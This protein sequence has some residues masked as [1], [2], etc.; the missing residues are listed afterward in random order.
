MPAQRGSRWLLPWLSLGFATV[1]ALVVTL[2][3]VLSPSQ[4]AQ[5]ASSMPAAAAGFQDKDKLL[6]TVNLPAVADGRTEGSLTLELLT[7]DGRVLDKTTQTVALSATSSSQRVELS[8]HETS[9]DKVTVRCTLDKESVKAPLSQIL[10]VKAHETALSSN[11]EFYAGSTA[12]LRC[13]VHGVKSLAETIPLPHA[14]VEIHLKDKNGKRT[15]LYTGATPANGIASARMQ[16]PAELPAGNYK[17]EVV[18]K[19]TLGEEKLERDVKVKTAPKIL[20]ISDKPLYQPGQ[21]M[22]LRALSLQSYD[23]TPV[24]NMPLTFEVEDAKGNKV[25]KRTLST[26]DHGIASVDF[27]LA[28]EVNT[29]E[30][31]IRAQ[32]GDVQSAKTVTVKPYVLPKF[33]SEL[34]ADKRFYLPRETLNGDLQVD[35]FFGKPVAGAQVV[36][37]AS[38]FDVAFKDFQ[39][40]QGKTDANGHAKFEIK[41][42]DY[43]T[44]LPLEKGNALV[45]LEAKVIDTA[46]HSEVINKTYPVSNQSVQINLIPEGG[47]LVPNMENRIFAAAIYPDG[48]PA[49]ADVSLWQGQKPEGKTLAALKTNE[50]GLAEFKFTPKAEMFRQGEFA[51]RKIEMLGGNTVQAWAPKQL[52]DLTATARDAKGNQAKTLISLTS[53]PLGENVMLRLDK[54]I[55]KGGEALKV[56]I[57]TSAGLPTVYF[58]VVRGG[59]TL[60]TQWLDVKDGVAEQTVELPASVFGTLDV[61]AYQMLGHGEIIRDSRVVYV[62]PASDLK[63]EIKADKDVYL[64][65]EKGNLNF[66]VK[67]AQGKPTAAALGVIIVD[68]AVYAL[69]EMQPG[70]EKVYFTLQ[71]ELLKPQAHI[72]YKP[73]QRIDDLVREPVLADARQQAAEVLFTSI[74]PRMPARWEVNPEFERRQKFDQMMPQIGSALFEV[75]TQQNSIVVLDRQTKTW[76]FAP[77]LLTTTFKQYGWADNTFPDPFGGKLK[78]ASL[79]R[80][81]A[82]CSPERLAHAVTEHRLHYLRAALLNLGNK[83]AAQWRKDDKWTLPGDVLRRGLKESAYPEAWLKDGW[84]NDFRLIRRD[85]KVENPVFDSFE[86][87]SA[88]PDGKLDT[89]DDVRISAANIGQL[90]QIWWMNGRQREELAQ[91]LNNPWMMRRGFGP[92][93]P[94]G[95][96]GHFA[97]GGPPGFPQKP[98]LPPMPRAPQTNQPPAPLGKPGEGKPGVD[99]EQGQGAEAAGAAPVV[100][101]REYFPETMLWQP[102]LITDDRGQASLPLNFADSITT[103]RLTASASSRG[104]LLGG[105]T[106]SL[107]VFQDF[108]ADIDLPV[109]LTRNDEVA[110]PVAVYNYLKTPQTVKLE[111][112][113][114]NWFELTDGLGLTRSLDL[115]PGQVTAVKFR[116]RAKQIG[117]LPLTVKAIGSKMSDSL[118]RSIEVVPDGKR[119]EQVFADRLNGRVN[120][121]ITIPDSALPDASKLLVKVYPGVFS[122]LVEGTEGMLRMPGGCFEQTSSSAY[123]NVLV[124]DYI[125][126]A[127]VASPEVLMK[128]EQY[129]NVGYQRLLTFERPGGGFDWWGSGEP[130]VWLS[131][132]GLSEFNDM[133]RVYPID[134]GVIERT[135]KWLMKQRAEDGTWDKI[136]ATHGESITRMGDPKLLLTSYVVWSLLD[137]GLKTPELNKSI[138]Y[139]RKGVKDA[140]NPYILALAANALASWDSK[141]DSTFEAVQKT[142]RKLESKKQVHE[143]WKA[144]SFPA[145]GHSLSYARGDSLTVETT[146]LAVLA[147]QKSGQ[148][149]TEVNKALMYLVKSKDAHGTWGSTQATIL[150]LK[151]LISG[152]GGS[153]HKG[154]VEFAILVNGKEAGKGEVTEENADVMQLFDLKEHTQRA[155][156]HNVTIEVK[157]ETNLM[158]QVVARHFEGWGEQKIDKPLF[159]VSVDYDRTRLQTS[160]LLKATARLKYNGKEPTSMVMLELG[161]PPG[162]TVD[163]GDFAELVAAKKVN[164]F[165]VTARQVILYLGDV[166][167]GDVQT[168]EYSLKPKYPIKAKT[169]A[170]VVYEYYT[171]ANRAEAKPVELV[172]E[173]K[174]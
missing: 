111:L 89:A 35:Y 90:G 161:V 72:L 152:M 26:S 157:G 96:G 49:Q 100:R 51:E 36:I 24:G 118:K 46:D 62:N 42:P 127:K 98:G 58:D 170:T 77:D 131:A 122:Q 153:P 78:I 85:G 16:L 135:Q 84:G 71:E 130:L 5:A 151:A 126:K 120:Q 167:P 172:V 28:S 37:K 45:R 132:Y 109:S 80:L 121:T 38:T 134:R 156:V 52:L 14:S 65:G 124:V 142:L 107:R 93:G 69:Q 6:I 174:K 75:A 47:R 33:K 115:Q 154:K 95:F 94:P 1:V 160:D 12:A 40:W 86:V 67:D 7:A 104:G 116:I 145:G 17:L 10:L 3:L 173:E 137:S 79:S 27:I 43:F 103:W 141:D 32:L 21:T 112:Q 119:I 110:F 60:L 113:A 143:E 73:S 125:K 163:A 15:A 57:H 138:E 68:E 63:I 149:T 140:E 83:H 54:A 61:H 66:Q 136:G 99:P 159:D 19:S 102:A 87:V 146:A 82:D 117:Q 114:E 22:H 39:T 88:G 31:Q 144:I 105:T 92:G 11:Q 91:N 106:T 56:K 101:T 162:F 74:K 50:A 81:S 8:L 20:L 164:K 76:Q 139:I 70:L 41:L 165:S 25:F 155:G 59:Q 168:I 13:S 44:G 148:F 55:Y 169:P 64:P 108:F 53:E 129:L 133:A 166:K 4:Q 2:V 34:K 9:A 128:A 123:P 150:A 147:M 29:G 23:L 18:T 30:Y 97:P 48:S 171:P 158:Y